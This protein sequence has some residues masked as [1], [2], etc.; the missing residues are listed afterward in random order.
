MKVQWHVLERPTFQVLEQEIVQK[1]KV[2]KV[3]KGWWKALNAEFGI[4]SVG[5][6]KASDS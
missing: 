2:K 6:G 4:Y 1:E 3:V 5:H